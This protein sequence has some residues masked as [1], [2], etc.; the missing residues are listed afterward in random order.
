[1][2]FNI[3]VNES[4]CCL[5]LFSQSD[6]RVPDFPANEAKGSHTVPFTSTIFIEQSDFREV[7]ERN[8]HPH[9]IC[10]SLV[11]Y[12]MINVVLFA[13][14]GEGLQ[15]SD[16]RTACWPEACWVCHFCPEGHKGEIHLSNCSSISVHA[17]ISFENTYINI[18][19]L[20]V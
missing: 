19:L 10:Q 6:I 13:G 14:D 3:M 15:A 17:N 2:I 7:R 12:M 11:L 4:F 1:M 20:F 9:I 8:K 5:P 18:S 16:T